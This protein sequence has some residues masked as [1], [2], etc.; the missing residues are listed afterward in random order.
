VYDTSTSQFYS[1]ADITHGSLI[2]SGDGNAE[3]YQLTLTDTSSSATA[4]VTGFAV[5]FY[6]QGQ[7]LTSDQ[8]TLGSPTFIT[9]GQSLVWTEQPWGQ[10]VSGRGASIGPFA[11]GDTGAVDT[12]A[13]CTLLQWYHQ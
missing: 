12:A 4:P 11:A 13:T 5:V 3:A 7:E 1:M 6:S 8:Q 10:S 9:P 2:P